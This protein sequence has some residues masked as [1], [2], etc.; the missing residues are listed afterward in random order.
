MSKKINHKQH[1]VWKSDS[2][3]LDERVADFSYQSDAL[4]EL[5]VTAW[6]NTTFRNQLVDMALSIPTRINNAKTALAG[7]GINLTNPI[8]LTESEFAEGWVRDSN[9]QV[10][11]VL[12]D[13]ARVTMTA[14]TPLLETAKLLMA[15]TPNGI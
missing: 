12:P 13:P 5:V 10:V 1:G 9:D 7:R 6:T 3:D 4:A 11:F 14:G 2:N 8:V 15:C